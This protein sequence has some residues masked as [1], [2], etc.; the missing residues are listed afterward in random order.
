VQIVKDSYF[1]LMKNAA[2]GMSHA[3]QLLD[4]KVDA[5]LKELASYPAAPNMQNQSRLKE[6]KRYCTDRIIQEPELEYATSCKR[7][8]YSLSDIL[9][10]TA[11][12]PTKENELLIIESSLIKEEPK[13][14]T[15]NEGEPDQT[16]SPKQPR[17]VRL[18]VG[19]KVMTVQAYKSLLTSQLSALAGAKP[20]DEIELDIETP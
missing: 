7:C 2:S 6:L 14:P 12:A 5:A 4:G 11:L 9:N 15:A 20:D 19:S 18:K 17:K 8:G 3:Y 16:A 13:A 1:K 10:Y